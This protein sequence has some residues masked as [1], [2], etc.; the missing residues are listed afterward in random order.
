MTKNWFRDFNIF[1]FQLLIRLTH[2]Y[3]VLNSLFTC[4]LGFV[5]YRTFLDLLNGTLD[6]FELL[7]FV[8]AMEIY[9]KE[10][11]DTEYASN[12]YFEYG[13]FLFGKDG[14]DQENVEED[15]APSEVKKEEILLGRS[16]AILDHH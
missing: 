16:D 12:H 3:L 7:R 9:V 10:A 13:L 1:I 5:L 15:L 8:L 4:S 11:A 14:N 2:L 6:P